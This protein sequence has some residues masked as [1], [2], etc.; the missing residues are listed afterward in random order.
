M[1]SKIT[2]SND[3]SAMKTLEKAALDPRVVEIEGHGMDEGRVFIHL[4]PEYVFY[5][6]EC[7]C[8]SVGSAAEVRMAMASIIT[9]EEFEQL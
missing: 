6:S 1:K 8:R 9:R 5:L 7:S 3:F 4:R 2:Y